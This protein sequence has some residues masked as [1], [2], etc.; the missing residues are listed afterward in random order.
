MPTPSQTT[1][2]RFKRAVAPGV[3]VLT[4]SPPQ[5]KIIVECNKHTNIK[6]RRVKQQNEDD[7]CVCV[8]STSATQRE[9]CTAKREGWAHGRSI[10]IE[11]LHL[12]QR[13]KNMIRTDTNLSLEVIM[14]RP[15]SRNCTI[16]ET[17]QRVSNY[18]GTQSCHCSPA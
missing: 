5:Q 13:N 15:K 12:L 10:G 14:P 11:M 4:E 18:I 8:D 1:T 3:V 9:T 2:P 16:H 17:Q 7:V 6:V